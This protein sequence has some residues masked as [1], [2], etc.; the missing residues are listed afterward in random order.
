MNLLNN[1]LK[2]K[3]D[4]NSNIMEDVNE[5]SGKVSQADADVSSGNSLGTASEIDIASQIAL[6]ATKTVAFVYGVEDV[7]DLQDSDDQVVVGKL[8]GTVNVGDT[9]YLTNFGIEGGAINTTTVVSI[10]LGPEKPADKAS[11]CHAAL[12][13]EKLKNFSVRIGTVVHSKQESVNEIYRRYYSTLADVYVARKQLA[14][15]EEELEKLSYAEITECW[16][17]YVWFTQNVMKPSNEHEQELIRDRMNKAA[18]TIT[19]KMKNADTICCVFSGYTGEPFM[20]S[21]TVKKDDGYLCS[22]VGIVLFPKQYEPVIRERMR[23]ENIEIREILNGKDKK[24]ICDFL[25]E[26]F[27]L[28]GADEVIPVFKNVSISGNMLVEKPDYSNTP[29]I[30]IPVMNPGI[31]KWMLLIAQLGEPQNDAQNTIFNLYFHFISTEIPNARFLIPMKGMNQENLEKPDAQGRTVVKKDTTLAI[32]TMKGKNG[33]DAVM[34]YTDWKRLRMQYNEEWNGMIVKMED[35]IQNYDCA[36]NVT[37]YVRAG[38]Y[39][40]KDMFENKKN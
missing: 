3:S 2:K 22:P 7:F 4:N 8:E 33:N 37:K 30:N 13:L 1:I 39:I 28:N 11:N 35:M 14:F 16:N 25:G 27:Y 32:A 9:V 34:M 21:Q 19:K 12:R 20:Y 23:D 26:T 10:E 29:P 5:S 24:G 6:S 15:T 31:V 40:T 17:L 38:S 36:I 18:K